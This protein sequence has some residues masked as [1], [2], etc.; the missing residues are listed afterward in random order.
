[1][2]AWLPAVKIVLPYLTQIV[3][4]SM[5]AFTRKPGR[6]ADDDMTLRQNTELQ[7]AATRNAES[8]IMLASQMEQLVQ[9]L[10]AASARIGKEVRATLWLA[11]AGLAMSTAA[12]GLS[13]YTWLR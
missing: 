7:D 9:A 2:A 11:I 3:T 10:D 4:T 6:G 8:I 13:L 12:M 5:P 1:M